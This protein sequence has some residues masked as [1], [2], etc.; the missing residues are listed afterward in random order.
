MEKDSDLLPELFRFALKPGSVEGLDLDHERPSPAQELRRKIVEGILY[1]KNFVPTYHFVI[2]ALVVL[3]SA[4]HLGEKTR[5]WR[6][7]AIKLRSEAL[8]DEDGLETPKAISIT[9]GPYIR[10]L[11]DSSTPSS[12]SST[13]LGTESPPRKDL[14]DDEQTPLLYTGH[15]LQPL[16]PRRT[17]LSGFQAFLMHQPRPMPLIQK[18]LPS[19][20]TSLAIIFF[21]G[22]NVF[23]TFW[24]I[25][26]EFVQSFVL[27]DRAGFL[28]VSNLPYLYILG[29]KNQPLKFLTGRSYE[30]L[31]LIHRRLGEVL[32]LQALV[33]ALGMTG[34]WYYFIRPTGFLTTLLDFL[35]LKIIVFGLIAFF[36][37]ELLYI[38]SLASF[39]QRWYEL[40]LGLHVVFQF[41]ALLFLFLHHPTGRPYVGAA[42]AI[43]IT[44]RA[45]YRISLKSLTVEAQ[46]T[47]M[48]DD[49]TVRLSTTIILQPPKTNHVLIGKSI[50]HGWQATDH[51]FITIPSLAKKYILQSHPFTIASQAPHPDEQMAK[52]DLL[53]RARDGFSADL[54]MRARSHKHLQVQLD[55]PYGSSHS[56]HLLESSDFQ[57]LVAGGSGIAVIWPLVQHLI[58]LSRSSDAENAPASPVLQKKIV[59]IWVIHKGEHLEWVGR[60]ALAD[61]EY[62]GVQT[63][64]PRATEEIG[65]PDLASEIAEVLTGAVSSGKRIGVVTSGPD[66]M[67]REVRN[68]CAGMKRNGVD[69][70]VAVE[71][72]GW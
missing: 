26:L 19:N 29:A 17:I 32:C 45:I 69:V 58:S 5:R 68:I 31:N 33:H 42:L 15:H 48:E 24:H 16:H 11:Q 72:F 52:L 50:A 51:V 71:K 10:D 7:R 61:A 65:R 3:F 46:A 49:E 21:L 22:I 70:D 30:S 56:R 59:V 12:G 43:F 55:G 44:D 47:I 60:Q 41:L 25:N 36:S 40:F 1:N 28:F 53:I 57:L 54:L 14:D 9:G 20:G 13:I 67:G 38:T 62:R 4:A 66:S 23:Y 6:R 64:V 34:A 27:A 63:I 2:L 37:Y 8:H 35:T 39:R 18:A